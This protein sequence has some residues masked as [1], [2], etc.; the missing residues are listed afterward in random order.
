[1]VSSPKSRVARK[2]ISKLAMLFNLQEYMFHE[3]RYSENFT[4]A[5]Y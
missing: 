5:S 4:R 3:C 1:M 2:K